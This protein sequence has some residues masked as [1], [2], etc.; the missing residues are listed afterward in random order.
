[1][2]RYPY[3]GTF[4]LSPRARKIQAIAFY[5]T[6]RASAF[7]NLLRVTDEESYGKGVPFTVEPMTC[8]EAHQCQMPI[9][10]EE[11]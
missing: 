8:E 5:A 4:K 9:A 7:Q 6:D 3:R 11:S 10:V 2:T 1:M